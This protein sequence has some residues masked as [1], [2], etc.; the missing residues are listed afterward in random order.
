MEDYE[1]AAE[2]IR[3][4]AH[5]PDIRALAAA[6]IVIACVLRDAP[7]ADRELTL[8]ALEGQIRRNLAVLDLRSTDQ[9]GAPCP[10]V[11]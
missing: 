8:E 1:L 4:A 11:N 5:Q 7:S 9:R 2:W 10:K 3:L 6:C